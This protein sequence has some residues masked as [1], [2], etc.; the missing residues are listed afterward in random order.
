MIIVNFKKEKNYPVKATKIKSDL[1]KK[2]KELGI[3]SDA[4]VSIALVGEKAMKD[5]GQKFL[6]EKESDP[7]HNVLSFTESEVIGKFIEPRAE[8]LKLGEI[9]VC[10]PVAKE[11]A[12]KQNQLIDEI[13]WELVEHG[14]LHLLGIHH[15]E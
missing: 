5:L 6:N 3:V 10:F 13:V 11:M 8:R 7:P 1:K 9:V 15:E 4:Q 12:T 2:L 14:T